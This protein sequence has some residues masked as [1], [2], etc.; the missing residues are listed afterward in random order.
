M[1]VFEQMKFSEGKFAKFISSKG[2]YVAIAL[3]LVG[4][5]AATW[6]AVDRTLGDIEDS[7]SRVISASASP[8]ESRLPILEEA[9]KKQEDVPKEPEASSQ[10][11]LQS[12]E[13][14]SEP[15]SASQSASQQ[16][17]APAEPSIEADVPP[18]PPTLSYSLPL[19]GDVINQFSK[20]ELV[21]NPVLNDWRTHDGVD[22]VGEEGAEIVAAADGTVTEIRS[23]P[24]WGT[25][26]TVSH[27]DERVSIYSGLSEVIPV[28]VGENVLAMQV[29]GKLEGVPCEMGEKPALHF[30]MKQDGVWI[31]PLS[32]IGVQE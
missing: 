2:F 21:K 16:A 17:L 31:D 23:D 29:I 1:E 28:K 11:T 25:V 10:A 19:D 8:G 26:L 4:A 18:P 22:I 7:N 13:V 3:G 32:V 24:L 12:S 6:L 9:D 15:E 27:A 20:G 30:A 14:L 5:G